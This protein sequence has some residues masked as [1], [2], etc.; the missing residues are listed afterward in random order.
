[1]A[2]RKIV[3][4][5]DPVLRTVTQAVD[6]VD[7]NIRDLIDDMFETM[8]H[9]NGVGLA[10]PQIGLSLR[11]AVIDASRDNSQPLVLINPEITR[12]GEL[13]E[14]QEGCL[15][16]PGPYET[17]KRAKSVTLKALDRN[18][19][20]YQLDAEGL[21]AEAIQH[22]VEHLDGKLFIDLLSPLK[23]NRAKRKFEKYLRYMKRR[24][25]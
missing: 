11:L 10:A 21:L 8:Y 20:T 18:G 4:L 25:A 3:Y 7:D 14:M 24:N 5:P 17:V 16:V 19:D 6:N 2:I 13:E 22:E 9:A 1:M 15:S 23:R 12:R